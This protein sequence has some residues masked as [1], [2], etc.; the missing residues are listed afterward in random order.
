MASIPAMNSRILTET[1]PASFDW[2]NTATFSEVKDVGYCG[3]SYAFAT[4]AFFE[5]ENIL[6]GRA[7]SSIDL[8]E[9]YLI[10]CNR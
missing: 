3:G 1:L 5:Q 9:M 8:S 2:R 4:I 7:N 6:A 10:A